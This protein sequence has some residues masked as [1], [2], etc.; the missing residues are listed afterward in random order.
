MD[1]A[2]FGRV[3]CE[4]VQYVIRIPA[5]RS[6]V[7]RRG[8]FCLPPGRLPSVGVA[9]QEKDNKEKK[10]FEIVR[11]CARIL[12]VPIVLL[13]RKS[14]PASFVRRVKE[15]ECQSPGVVVL[16]SCSLRHCSP[17]VQR[18]RKTAFR[19]STTISSQATPSSTALV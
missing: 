13:R 4:R 19:F 7:S 6:S 12:H 9:A 2:G 16:R 3:V 15:P 11:R 17:C 18:L 1:T 5:T 14:T 8:A 10:R